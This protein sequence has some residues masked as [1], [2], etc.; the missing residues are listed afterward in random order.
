MEMSDPELAFL[1]ENPDFSFG[2][3]KRC[4]NLDVMENKIFYALLQ[5]FSSHQSS[6]NADRDVFLCVCY[7]M[8]GFC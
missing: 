6:L 2:S 8:E 7:N 3:Y 4:I 5:L 1:Y